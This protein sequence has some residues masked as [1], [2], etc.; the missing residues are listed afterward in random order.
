[1]STKAKRREIKLAE[2]VGA[3]KKEYDNEVVDLQQRTAVLRERIRCNTNAMKKLLDLLPKAQYTLSDANEF[4]L[5]KIQDADASP[6]P[7]NPV[8]KERA[9]LEE[10]HK[11]L[12]E[13]FD[14]A[15]QRLQAE[16]LQLLYAWD[17]MFNALDNKFKLYDKKRATYGHY[18]RKMQ[19]LAAARKK[20]KAKGIAETV[21]NAEQWGRNKEK[22]KDA[23]LAYD[24]HKADFI[25][26][27]KSL[28]ATQEPRSNL[29]LRAVL[30]IM[31][32]LFKGLVEDQSALNATMDKLESF[33]TQQ[34]R[35]LS[36]ELDILAS[37]DRDTDVDADDMRMQMLLHI[38]KTFFREAGTPVGGAELQRNAEK[39]MED[40]EP[41]FQSLRQKYADNAAALEALQALIAAW[42]DLNAASNSVG[43]SVSS[44]YF[45]GDR[46]K[47]LDG[48]HLGPFTADAN[49]YTCDVCG[50]RQALGSRMFSCRPCNFDVCQ[51]C[52]STTPP[53]TRSWPSGM[54]AGGAAPGQSVSPVS[55][56]SHGSGGGGGGGGGVRAPVGQCF[57]DAKGQLYFGNGPGRRNASASSSGGVRHQQRRVCEV[58]CREP[59]DEQGQPREEHR[60]GSRP[61]GGLR[62]CVEQ[63]VA[64]PQAHT[65][66]V[67]RQKQPRRLL[68]QCRASIIILYARACTIRTP[69]G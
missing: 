64:R 52:Y 69:N 37:V 3:V 49:D 8:V 19:R 30:E 7:N 51:G 43:P 1:M 18:G 12:L 50:R 58:H 21:K 65:E 15:V 42:E 23:R 14:A 29:L 56:D 6:D 25:K 39:L 62:Q 41:Y 2:T 33:I 16:I 22:F 57:Q 54:G 35:D 63:Y 27:S 11:S 59:F 34:R 24:G 60:L 17:A 38:L 26:V 45:S 46:T 47:C 10:T 40:S 20:R 48:H 55:W 31:S 67:R 9:G 66:P 36:N 44:R 61:V 68:R 28:L 4:I 32:S 53:K 13:N 5:K